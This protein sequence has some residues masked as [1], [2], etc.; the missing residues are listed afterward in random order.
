[1]LRITNDVV[2]RLHLEVAHANTADNS[3]VYEL[4]EAL[5]CLPDGNFVFLD[6]ATVISPPRLTPGS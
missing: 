5:P 1:M 2:Q 4:L 6:S 3:F